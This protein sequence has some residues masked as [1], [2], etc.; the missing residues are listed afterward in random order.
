MPIIDSHTH[1]QNA[2]DAVINADLQ[3]F[4]FKEGLHYSIGL[5]PWMVREDNDA[6]LNRILSHAASANVVAIGE[7]GID[8]LKAA[9]QGISISSEEYR[10]LQTSILEKHIL[11]SEAVGKPLILHSVRAT[12][13]IISLKRFFKPSQPWI[14]HGFRAKPTVL[15][16]LLKEGLFVSY[17]HLFNEESLRATPLHRL[18]IETDDSGLAINEVAAKASQCLGITQ[19]KLIETVKANNKLIFGI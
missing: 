11:L 17:G 10:Q 12:N 7:C 14:I 1:N 16:N 5:H 15:Q 19:D 4:G 3:N 8:T 2:A 18:L 6:L 9:S 13:D